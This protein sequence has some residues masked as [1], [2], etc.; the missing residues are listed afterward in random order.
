MA[1][2]QKSFEEKTSGS[3]GKDLVHVK[4]VKSVPSDKEGYWRFN[5]SMIGLE[6]GQKLDAALKQMED[7]A[8][9][10]DIEM[11]STDSEPNEDLIDQTNE[12]IV[13]TKEA[14]AEEE[15]PKEEEAPAEE[16]APK[17]E[18]A[19]AE[20]ETPKEEEAPAE[21]EAPKEE[22]APAEEEAPKEEEAPAEEEAR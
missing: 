8:N 12:E 14:P 21:E 2:K 16:E 10:V 19:P 20:E 22:E 18:E 7:E 3:K 11:P 1:K 13:E 4:F 6:K 5:E 17:E 15:T 9:L